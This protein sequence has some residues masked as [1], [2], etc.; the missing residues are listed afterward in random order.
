M[1]F[2]QMCCRSRFFSRFILSKVGISRDCA[3]LEMR[4][5]S[6]WSLAQGLFPYHL[7]SRCIESAQSHRARVHA[8]PTRASDTALRLPITNRGKSAS[9][10]F[11]LAY[12][13]PE[14]LLPKRVSRTNLEPRLA[15]DMPC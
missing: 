2:S 9:D 6:R 15:L 7:A 8:L 5:S 12:I 14:P 3:C 4:S 10:H 11:R 1:F 13:C